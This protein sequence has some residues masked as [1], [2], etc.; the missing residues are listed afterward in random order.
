MKV[1]IRHVDSTVTHDCGEMNPEQLHH[2]VR[3]IKDSGIYDGETEHNL[4]DV[5]VQYVQKGGRFFA[6]VFW[7]D[8]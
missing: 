8:E 2:F 5:G 4:I 7:S 3:D 1:F 6:E